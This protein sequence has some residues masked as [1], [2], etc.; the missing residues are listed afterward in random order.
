M[1]S[2]YY[3]Q[4]TDT[5]R[6]KKHEI[7]V[8]SFTA[9]PQLEPRPFRGLDS[10]VWKYGSRD[11]ELTIDYGLYA[12]RPEKGQDQIEHESKA[13]SI[14]GYE[15]VLVFSRPR[16]SSTNKLKFQAAIYVLGVG[17]EKENLSFV[18]YCKTAKEQATA[19]EI[20]RTIK[21]KP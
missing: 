6:W 4:T 2:S 11:L 15:A 21:F 12:T 1:N 10:E 13:I 8:L 18:V 20:F 3:S 17:R 19:E 9:P 7:R 5:S 16:N 14:D